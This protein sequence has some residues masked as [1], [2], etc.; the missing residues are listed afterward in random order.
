[1]NKHAQAISDYIS[2]VLEPEYDVEEQRYHMDELDQLAT[3][4]TDFM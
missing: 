1:M 2:E 3:H 4:E